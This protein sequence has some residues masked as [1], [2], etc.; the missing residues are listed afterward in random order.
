MKVIAQ[1]TC[2]GPV[3]HDFGNRLR[4]LIFLCVSVAL[5]IV[6]N[7]VLCNVPH[8][9]ANQFG[10]QEFHANTAATFQQAHRR[11]TWQM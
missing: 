10:D 9:D 5:R 11:T 1:M 3:A 2:I 6:V 4:I 7:S 8:L